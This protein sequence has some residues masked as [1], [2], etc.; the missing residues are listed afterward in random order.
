M[1]K[2]KGW[3]G[4]R[5]RHSTAKRG[6]R[7]VHKT[8]RM[9]AMGKFVPSHLKKWKKADNYMG[10][11]YEDYYVVYGIHR[12]SN[13]LEQSNWD[14][15][16]KALGDLEGV[17]IVR[18]SHW[19]VGWVE[20]ILVHENAEEPL[21]KAE[22]I[23]HQY[24]RYSVLDDSDFCDRE[25]EATIENIKSEGK[26]SD[27]KATEVYSYLANHHPEEIEG[28]DLSGGWVSR[29]RIKSALLEMELIKHPKLKNKSSDA[30]KYILKQIKPEEI[31]DFIDGDKT[32]KQILSTKKL[33]LSQFDK[34]Q[35]RL[36]ASG[37]EGR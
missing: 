18:A 19:G 11:T 28:H 31:E 1:T 30:M 21:M 6:I 13:L 2:R 8:P 32:I 29:E 24:E 33:M 15:I 20:N 37:K 25:T 23:M 35:S 16:V 9:A 7:T 3:T 10:E 14:Y 17:E 12:D 4:E 34:K 27:E 22:D 26:L 36:P 5:Q